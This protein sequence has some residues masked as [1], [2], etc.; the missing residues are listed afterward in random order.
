M[1]KD[2]N[3]VLVE[4]EATAKKQAD[5]FNELSANAKFAEAN[6]MKADLI[7]TINKYTSEARNIAFNECKD[8]DDP[9]KE[10]CLRV[11]YDTIRLKETPIEGSILKEASIVDTRKE[12]NLKK[13]DQHC[14]GIGKD[15]HW[16][17]GIQ[18]FNQFMTVRQ[19]IRCNIDPNEV[20]G[21]YHMKKITKDLELRGIDPE[22]K[23]LR[24]NTK[25]F[26]ENF[27]ESVTRQHLNRII[28]MMIGTEYQ[29]RDED[30]NTFID[31]YAKLDKKSK[32]KV[33][34]SKHDQLMSTLQQMCFAA[35]TGESYELV[36]PKVKG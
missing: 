23:K 25:K 3:E 11:H 35:M 13:L 34:C 12:I 5:D 27:S 28:G 7:Q 24:Y 22:T 26:K 20:F 2:L 31:T 1:A 16:Y 36:F 14:K 17:S 9:M 19:A 15:P 29:V 32:L 8:A 21:S 4:L 18:Q 30:F 10:A 6:D 33:V